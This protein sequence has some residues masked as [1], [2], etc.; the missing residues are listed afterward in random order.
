MFSVFNVNLLT[1]MG[2]TIVRKHLNT[3]DAQ[4]VWRELSDHIRTSSQGASNKRR[5]A[6]YVTNIIL[7]DNLKGT[8]EQFLLHFNE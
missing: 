8:T 7:D 4:T 2:K 5:L 3:T 6:Q 1:D